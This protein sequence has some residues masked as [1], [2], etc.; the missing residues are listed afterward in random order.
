[1]R[2]Y[3]GRLWGEERQN[4]ELRGTLGLEGGGEGFLFSSA[5]EKITERVTAPL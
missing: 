1:M 4:S 5:T 3:R 2:G